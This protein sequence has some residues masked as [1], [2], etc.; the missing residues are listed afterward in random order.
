MGLLDFD[1]Y[2]PW[3][4]MREGRAMKFRIISA[5]RVQ[6]CPD[7]FFTQNPRIRQNPIYEHRVIPAH[8]YVFFFF[9]PNFFVGGFFC[10]P[11]DP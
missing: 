8:V 6:I 5:C 3:D 4:R 7:F 10:N 1:L 2:V 9:N 11:E